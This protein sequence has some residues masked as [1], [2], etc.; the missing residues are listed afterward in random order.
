MRFLLDTDIMLEESG[1]A[2]AV[3]CHSLANCAYLP[4]YRHSPVR[5]LL[6]ADFLKQVGF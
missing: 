1:G 6:P 4:N 5:V 3:A 2:A